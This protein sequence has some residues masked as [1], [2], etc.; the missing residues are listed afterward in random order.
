MHFKVSAL[1]ALVAFGVTILAVP[2]AEA[3]AEAAPVTNWN[4]RGPAPLAESALEERDADGKLLPRACSYTTGCRSK[5]G[6]KAGRYCG[7]CLQVSASHTWVGTH[8]YQ[9][10]GK[11]SASGCC[12]YGYSSTCAAQ[13]NSNWSQS[14][15]PF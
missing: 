7:Y 3:E 14:Y 2:V 4:R 11:T 8:V 6:V 15:C 12:D 10:N 9:L 1:L 5:S 13:Y